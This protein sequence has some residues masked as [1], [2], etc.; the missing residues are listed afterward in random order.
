M[1]VSR[2]A[3]N[4]TGSFSSACSGRGAVHIPTRRPA[5]ADQCRIPD[6]EDR[7]DIRPEGAMFCRWMLG[8][9]HAD[10][11]TGRMGE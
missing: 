8:Y 10:A 3:E 6:V 4:D 9:V 2:K 5:R 11:S 7:K 1:V